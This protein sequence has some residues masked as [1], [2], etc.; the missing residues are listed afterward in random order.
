MLEFL[1]VSPIQDVPGKYTVDK[2]SMD[3]LERRGLL[4]LD[5]D[6][7]TELGAA[8]ALRSRLILPCS[9]PGINGQLV[10]AGG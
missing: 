4:K 3:N 9:F 7:Y 1:P 2:T 10:C 5:F 8:I 6:G